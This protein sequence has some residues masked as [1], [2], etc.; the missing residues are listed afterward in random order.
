MT[1]SEKEENDR[2]SH[3]RVIVENY[4][5][6]LKSLWGVCSHKWEWDRQSYDIFFRACL[7]LTNYSV[8]CCPLRREDG[9][10]Y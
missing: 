1:I 9:D 10:N 4:F 6:R 8:R 5:G 7:A 3:D 2:I